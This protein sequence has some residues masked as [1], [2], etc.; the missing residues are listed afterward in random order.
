MEKTSLSP[1]NNDTPCIYDHSLKNR[2]LTR[3]T[4]D[5]YKRIPADIELHNEQVTPEDKPITKLLEE[6][7][8]KKLNKVSSAV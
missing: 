7:T 1:I 3:S 4:A 8:L 5:S 6:H 2:R